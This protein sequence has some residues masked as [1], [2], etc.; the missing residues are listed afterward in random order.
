MRFKSAKAGG[1]QVFA[2]SGTNTVSFGIDFDPAGTAGL[3]GFAVE[4]E[5]PKENQRYYMY[6]FK[7]FESIFPNPD[8][9][10]KVSTFDH[11]VQSFV[12]DDFTA[13]PD[14][15]YTYHFHPL[16]GQ[17]KNLDRTAPAIPIKIGT[18]K[19]SPNGAHDIF[20]NRGVASS[21]AYAREFKNMKPSD[22]P[23]P[24]RKRALQWLSRDL[25]E[26]MFKFIDQA[27]A[28]DTLL[29]AFYEFRYLPVALRLKAAIDRGVDVKLVLDAKK[30]GGTDNDGKCPGLS[31]YR[32][33]ENGRRCKAAEGGNR[34]LAREECRCDR[35][36]QV[37][38]ADKGRGQEADASVDRLN[39]YFGGRHTRADQCRSLGARQHD[40]RTLPG[41]LDGACG[42]SRQ[43]RNG[44]GSAGEG[45]DGRVSCFGHRHRPH[46]D[47]LA[48]HRSR[49]HACFQSARRRRRAR[50][51]FGH[52]GRGRR[53]RLHHPGLRYQRGVQGPPGQQ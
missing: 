17:P 46:P 3:L 7:V 1:F 43:T 2:V 5:D 38:G 31:A 8:E 34:L 22:L 23:E 11:P 42:R 20:F 49:H 18:E 24:K 44:N 47:R 15:E 9:T 14:R 30:N 52:A 48:D 32:Q 40:C 36:Q 26:A 12:W 21:Q 33:P 50:H 39:Q 37:H 4:R 28:G 10:L 41:L 45:G 13:K 6:G 53:A 19:L 27:K 51:V 35:A 25:D 16:K 29:G